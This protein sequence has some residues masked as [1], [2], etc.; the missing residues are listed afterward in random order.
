M[1]G[2]IEGHTDNVGSEDVNQ[3]LS[4]RRAAAIKR[5][6]IQNFGISPDRLQAEGYGMS[7]PVVDNDTARG[8]SKNRRIEAR[9]FEF[10]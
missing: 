9:F 10:G 8:R 4:E 7:R 5:Y 6:L 1:K 2:I 3:K